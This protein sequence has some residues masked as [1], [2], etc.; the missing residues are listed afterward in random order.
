MRIGQAI[1]EPGGLSGLMQATQSELTACSTLEQAAQTLVSLIYTSFS[2]SIVLARLFATIP[3]ADLLP[4]IQRSADAFASSRRIVLKDDTPVLTLL[5]TRGELEFWNGRQ[6]SKGHAGIPLTSSAFVDELPMI[7]RLLKQIGV[8]LASL[9]GVEGEDI[10]MRNAG[11]IGGAFHVPDAARSTDRR[12]RK[13]IV[14]QEFVK[15]YCVRSVFGVGGG[16]LTKPMFVTLIVFARDPISADDARR[17]LPL[18]SQ[19]K[20]MTDEAVRQGR[21]FSE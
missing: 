15:T 6:L 14:S 13:I 11:K 18:A 10:V 9:E 17:F 8:R 16:Y 21:L 1:N 20:L 2:E 3:Y 12:G 19:F 5:G 7:S 4:D